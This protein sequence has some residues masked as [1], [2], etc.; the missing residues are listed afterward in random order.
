MPKIKKVID[1]RETQEQ[2]NK[3]ATKKTK[4]KTGEVRVNLINYFKG[5]RII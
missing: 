3:Q 1:E 2:T 4:K 5:K